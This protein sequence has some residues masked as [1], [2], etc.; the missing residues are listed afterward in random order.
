MNEEKFY[1]IFDLTAG[2]EIAFDNGAKKVKI[3]SVLGSGL[4]DVLTF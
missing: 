2:T 3:V 4:A 1:T